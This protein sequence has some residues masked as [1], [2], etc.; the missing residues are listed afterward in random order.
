MNCA[1]DV[2]PAS[3]ADFAVLFPDGQDVEFIEDF[4]QRVG[5][6]K[7]GDI[8]RRLYAKRADKKTIHGIHGTLFYQLE[9][10]KQF[11]PTK[12]EAD[13]DV[14]RGHQQDTTSTA[15]SR[16]RRARAR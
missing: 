10:K 12:R 13:L 1:Y 15:S 16:R 3:E 5:A 7:A 4:W 9:F 6:K 2:F 8:V 14:A 11:Y